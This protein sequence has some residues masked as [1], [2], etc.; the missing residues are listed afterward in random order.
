MLIIKTVFKRI[1]KHIKM[2]NFK[3]GDSISYNDHL[4][5]IS[6]IINDEIYI[7]YICNCDIIEYVSSTYLGMQCKLEKDE[8][9][10]V[11]HAK[12]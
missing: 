9:C 7:R 11:K 4:Y 2:D 6:D 10:K 8:L 1:Y 5:Q 12:S 3:K